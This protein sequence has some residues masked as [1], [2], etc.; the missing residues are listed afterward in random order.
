M[1]ATNT[2]AAVG[3]GKYR[4]PWRIRE[5]LDNRNITMMD[6]ANDLGLSHSV[7]SRTVKGT[8][9][10]SKVLAR[11]LAIGCPPRYLSL[12]KD[13]LERGAS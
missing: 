10:N 1:N 12:P 3:A 5:F 4:D 13:M 7:V 8:Q 11:L 9:N 6:I 2:H